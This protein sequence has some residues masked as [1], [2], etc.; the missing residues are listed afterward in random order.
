MSLNP[1]VMVGFHQPTILQPMMPQIG[2]PIPVQQLNSYI[3][4]QA[5]MGPPKA[6]VPP[7]RIMSARMMANQ[8]IKVYFWDNSHQCVS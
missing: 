8:V 3:M 5:K 1:Q 2:V 6:N 4:Q 7:Q